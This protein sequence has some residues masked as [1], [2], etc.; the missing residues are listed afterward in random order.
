MN[1]STQKKLLHGEQ[2]LV[3]KGDG[4]VVEWIGTLGLIDVNYCLWNG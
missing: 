3:A 4:D 1:L 2:T